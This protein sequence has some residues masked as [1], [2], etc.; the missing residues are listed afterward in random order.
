MKTSKHNRSLLIAFVS[1]VLLLSSQNVFADSGRAWRNTYS[2]SYIGFGLRAGM[3]GMKTVGDIKTTI[4][5]G[6]S[7]GVDLCYMGEMGRFYGFIVGL[8]YVE[9][10][11]T[12]DATNIKSGYDGDLWWGSTGRGDEFLLQAHFEG[13]TSTVREVMK[14]HILEIPVLFTFASERWY[15]GA[16]AKFVIPFN[17]TSRYTVGETH[18]II[19][20]V[21]TTGTVLEEGLE[22]DAGTVEGIDGSYTVFG[23]GGKMVPV[24]VLAALEIGYRVQF[25]MNNR[26]QFSI[27]GEYPISSM[28]LNNSSNDMLMILNENEIKYRGMANANQLTGL[29]FFTFGLRIQYNFGLGGAPR[30]GRP[31][32][33][34]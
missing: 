15:L 22:L 33:V 1:C 13:T 8:S 25:S 5:P 17:V 29:G 12:I 32:R 18:K 28:S 14:A 16:G 31:L 24:S 3:A 23:S 19:D 27:Y 2:D 6:F 30:S 20:R 9:A 11:F 21:Y 10:N 26:M 34:R 7:Y 4:Q